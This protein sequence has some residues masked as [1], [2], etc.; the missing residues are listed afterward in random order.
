MENHSPERK[1]ENRMNSEISLED[2]RNQNANMKLTL[3]K[4]K[5]NRDII[6]G[7]KEKINSIYECHY[8]IRINLLKTNNDEIRN[9]YIDLSNPEDSMKKLKYLL[10][11]QDDNEIKF[12]LLAIRKFFQEK[13]RE[14]Y[15]KKGQNTTHK[16]SKNEIK[17]CED[18]DI[19]IKNK[20]IDLLFEILNKNIDK[21]NKN[22]YINIYE[23]S[24]IFI[25]MT[26][27][28]P[29]EE[30]KRFEFFNN[31]LNKNNL[32]IL[33]NLI[34]INI[35]QE[36]I[37]NVLSLFSNIALE[38]DACIDVLVNSSLTQ[39]IFNYLKANKNINK[40]ILT[41]IYRVLYILYST[42]RKLDIQANKILFKIFSLPLYNFKNN[43]ILNYCLEMLNLLSKNNDPQ[44]ENCFNDINIF[45]AFNT[46]IFD[47]NI[48][49]NENLINSILDI[50]TNLIEKKNPE[51]EKNI[52]NSGSCLKFYNNLLNK[53]KKENKI[54]DR[55]AEEN[56]I[57]AINNVILFDN[58]DNIKYIFGEGREILNFFIDSGKSIF[59]SMRNLGIKSFLNILMKNNIDI[60]INII[61]DMVNIVNDTLMLEEFSNCYGECLK[62]SYVI[63][64]KSRKMNF[65]NDLKTYLNNKGFINY[66]EKI[67][68]KLLNNSKSFKFDNDDVDNYLNIID[69]IKYF[70]NN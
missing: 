30:N 5:R 20:I 64:E 3:R 29:N 58:S 27:I 39:V 65:K 16:L 62:V 43:E 32:N 55:K 66:I 25:N 35:P 23:I 69:E 59:Q 24:W 40:E 53:Y 9:F 52:I 36:I 45:S 56:I 44:I 19:F 60:D 7:L 49:G 51:L 61:F 12:G 46:I 50:F 34:K 8:N 14:L 13:V 54:I 26:S 31:L 11:S 68:T 67:E 47:F 57:I 63:M 38:E 17:K 37:T 10:S 22:S 42:F 2:L 33:I 41:K 4:E 15:D 48:E 21:D 18:F 28:Y 1:F 70:L 6:L